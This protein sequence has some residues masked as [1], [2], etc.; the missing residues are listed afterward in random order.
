VIGILAAVTIVSYTSISQKASIA[1]LV[2]DL[3]NAS[4]QFK[5]FQV[6]NSAYPTSLDANNCPLP[7]DSAGCLKA[8]PG[9][10]YTYATNNST[11]P[12]TFCATATKDGQIYK[13]TNDSAPSAGN[14]LDYMQVL[15]LDAG[16]TSSYPSPFTG[17]V[18]TDLSGN[19]NNGTLYNG[20][21]YGVNDV[22]KNKLNTR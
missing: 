15:H 13:I 20:V 22:V 8:S 17:T 16:N 4:K 7:T 6:T 5:L 21:G 12:Q 14:C 3:D 9:V 2:S 11:I 19:S 10:T 18:W 1:S